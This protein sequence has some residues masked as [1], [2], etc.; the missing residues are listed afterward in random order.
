MDILNRIIGGMNKEQIR[1][2]KLYATRFSKGDRKDLKLFDYIRKTGERY[3]ETKV[4]DRLYPQGGKNPFYRLKNR[5]L[6]D[7]NKSIT[8]QFFDEEETMSALHHLSLARYHF[9]K[10]NFEASHYFVR[11]AESKAQSVENYELL[12][13]IYGE[14]I[15]LSH[16]KTAINPEDYIAKR[17]TNRVA[18][19]SLR[20]IDDVLAAVAYRLKIT[21]NF[22]PEENPVLPLL[23]KTV[24]DFSAG[25]DLVRSPKLRFKLYHAVSQILLQRR[26]YLALEEYLLGVYHEFAGEKLFTRNNH[27]TKLQMLTYLVNALFKNNR[28][29]ESLRYAEELRKAMEEYHHLLYDKYFFFYYNSQV[30]NYSKLDINKAI[31]ILEDLRENEKIKANSFYTTFVFLNLVLLY[32]DKKQYKEAIKLLNKLY[33]L[34]GYR[35]TDPAI[36]FRIAVAELIIRYE[37]KDFDLLEYKIGQVRSDFK[38]YLKQAENRK[39]KEFIGILRSIINSADFLEQ[40]NL[41]KRV[42]KFL[43]ASTLTPDEDTEIISYKKWLSEKFDPLLG[44]LSR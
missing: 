4:F 35:S 13:V 2:F 24:N 19:D 22:S 30:I 11:K 26:D 23:Q 7:L 20:A 34:D 40:K 29:E 39:E 1:F 12:D 14:F 38:A 28:L 3:D 17:K 16:E 32:F 5:L 21:Q 41:V 18:I 10:N 37:L 15:R 27:D 43:E 42:I 9:L 33:Q 8:I 25:G 6:G 44:S 31:T 36:R